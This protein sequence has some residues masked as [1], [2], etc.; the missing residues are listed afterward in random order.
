MCLLARAQKAPRRPKT[1]TIYTCY[2]YTLLLPHPP[3][4]APCSAPWPPFRLTLGH[5]IRGVRGFNHTPPLAIW[6][7]FH[8]AAA[9]ARPRCQRLLAAA[10]GP[11]APVLG[12]YIPNI[13]CINPLVHKTSL[14][15]L[16]CHRSVP[17]QPGPAIYHLTRPVLPLCP[18]PLG[19]WHTAARS[20]ALCAGTPPAKRAPSHPSFRHPVPPCPSAAHRPPPAAPAPPALPR[21]APRASCWYP[22]PQACTQPPIP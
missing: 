22:A 9:H 7:L 19:C 16:W 1:S 21:T 17:F 18:P 5:R 13:Q 10:F 14:D 4:I 6:I 8:A 2:D 12:P 3:R 20:P 15:V 11:T